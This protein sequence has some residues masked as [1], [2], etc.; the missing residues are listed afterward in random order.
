MSIKLTIPTESKSQ[1]NY[2][3]NYFASHTGAMCGGGVAATDS[4][5]TLTRENDNTITASSNYFSSAWDIADRLPRKWGKW[6]K[7]NM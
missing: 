2:V 1:A 4:V 7:E 6:I 5:V 3:L